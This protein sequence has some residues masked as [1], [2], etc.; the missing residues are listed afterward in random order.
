[1]MSILEWNARTRDYVIEAVDYATASMDLKDWHAKERRAQMIV[2]C[3]EF[4]ILQDNSQKML[5]GYTTLLGMHQSL[6]VVCVT[7]AFMAQIAATVS[8]PTELCFASD[9]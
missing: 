5:E 7:K 6:L 8:F 2:A 4:V 1:M 9:L 3:P